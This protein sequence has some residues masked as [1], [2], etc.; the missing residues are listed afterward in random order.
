MSIHVIYKVGDDAVTMRHDDADKATVND[1]GC[2][3]LSTKEGP[4]GTSRSGGAAQVVAAYAPGQ[5]V[6]WLRVV[7]ASE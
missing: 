1:S 5:W 7:P 4:P 6:R 2:L 3:V